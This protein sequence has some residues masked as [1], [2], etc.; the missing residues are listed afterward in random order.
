M[1]LISA[2]LVAIA[3]LPTPAVAQTLTTIDLTYGLGRIYDAPQA[4]FNVFHVPG[5]EVKLLPTPFDKLTFT[6]QLNFSAFTGENERSTLEA[7]YDRQLTQRLNVN[8]EFEHITYHVDYYDRSGIQRYQD[9]R[10]FLEARYR[11]KQ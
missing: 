7:R 9:W 2:L 3:L 5:V 1:K 8:F 11:I 10:V 4:K 6:G